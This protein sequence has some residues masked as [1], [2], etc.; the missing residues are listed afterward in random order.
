MDRTK[1][2]KYGIR[3]DGEE[4]VVEP[5]VRDGASVLIG[6]RPYPRAVGEK[7]DLLEKA[8]RKDGFNQTVERLAYTWFNRL[9]AIR[10]MELHGYLDHGYRVLSHPQGKGVPE[11]LEQ[12][13]YVAL[14]GLDKKKVIDLKLDGNKDEELYRLLLIAQCNA[15]HSAMPFLFERVDDETELAL[16]E[17]LLHSDSLVRKLV[18]EIGEEDW[19]E[20]EIIGWLYEAYISERYE[21]VIGKVV[22]AEDIPA[23]TQRFT[24]KW[25][26]RYLVQNTLGRTWLATYPESPLREQMKYYI[27]PAEQTEEVKGQLKD[28]TPTSLNPEEIT[29]LD[30]ACGSGHILVEA[31]DLYKAI[32]QERGYRSRDIPRLI[33]AKNLF[34]LEIDDRAAQ[35]AAFALLM[36]ARADDV[37]L[38]GD[39]GVDLNILGIRESAGLNARELAEYLNQPVLLD[40]LPTTGRLFDEPG[41]LFTRERMA[42]KGEIDQDD[43]AAIIGTFEKV[44]SRGSLV[45]V[46]DELAK[47]LPGIEERTSVV[48]ARGEGFAVRHAA[49]F[50]PL[51]RQARCLDRQFDCVVTNPPYMGGKYL[52]GELKAWIDESY[53]DTKADLYA[54]FI[55]RC[56]SAAKQAGRIGMITFDKWTYLTPTFTN[57]RS[58]LA[59]QACIES[60][61][62]NGRG[63]FGSDYPTCSFVLRS[64]R[65][66][67][68]VG[69]F[70]RLFVKQGSVADNE[71]LE[72][73]F[74]S[75]PNFLA[76]LIDF[77]EFP[78]KVI[79]YWAGPKVL[80]AFKSNP[81][82]GS[83]SSPRQGLATTDDSRFLR[84]WHEVSSLNSKYDSRSST[85]ARDSRRKWF[86]F[87][88]GGQFR[89]WFGNLEH[90]INWLNN[91]E[92][93]TSLIRARYGSPAKRIYNT[94]YY[95]RP[96]LTWSSVTISVPSFRFFGCGSIISHVGPGIF[97]ETVDLRL[98]LG[99]LN[100]CVVAHF[101]SFVSPSAHFEVGQVANVPFKLPEQPVS[102]IVDLLLQLHEEDWN[103]SETSWS[104]ARSP[105][106]VNGTEGLGLPASHARWQSCCLDRQRRASE[107]EAQNNR[108]F[109]DTFELND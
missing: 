58:D 24:P 49:H 101:L 39:E 100:S 6:G 95:F 42:A 67:G 55:K 89:R 27:E 4:L 9:V 29:F 82:L 16:P 59:Q 46:P 14:P 92:E 56:Q 36:K 90:V 43:I 50:L 26:V 13:E 106:L 8:V 19:Q 99:Y 15:L 70:R 68:E 20:V 94:E 79:A 35:L 10:Y 65:L 52:V 69:T 44:K 83:V 71:E 17:N 31:Y 53:P 54:C 34:G 40:D 108:A 25:I 3:Q 38:F 37:R 81:S 107:L 105:L 96:G 104:F 60:F 73:R 80:K 98:L 45:R 103:T 28:I 75:A 57:L 91:G 18:T 97:S 30:P 51:V 76:S 61:V 48:A 22:A 86:P 33:L 102:H 72:A 93:L 78:G 12:A 7:R 85:E 88:K 84:L 5:L 11:V 2:K 23:A 32:Y 47:K 74:H 77:E 109:I 21:Q 64:H 66:Q 41:T 1:I 87:N 63:V 62:H